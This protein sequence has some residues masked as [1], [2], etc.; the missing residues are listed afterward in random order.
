MI[1]GSSVLFL[2]YEIV[3]LSLDVDVS[4]IEMEYWFKHKNLQH[5]EH[6]LSLIFFFTNGVLMY[7]YIHLRS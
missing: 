4:P 5:E 7:S 1:L 6:P 2:S 3:S